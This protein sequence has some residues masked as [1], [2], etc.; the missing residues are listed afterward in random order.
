MDS[1]GILKTEVEDAILKGMKWKEEDTGKWHAQ[2]A[3]VEIV[4]M[5]QDENFVIITVYL[6]RREK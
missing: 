6:A 3:G 2:M 5:K 1:I 4:F